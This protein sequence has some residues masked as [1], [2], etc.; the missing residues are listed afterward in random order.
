MNR[1][2]GLLLLVALTGAPEVASGQGC[3]T[4]GSS[5]LG[6]LSGS[7]LQP[8][9]F[10]LGV[11]SEAF[12]LKQAYR[13]TSRVDDA[14]RRESR[15]FTA[16]AYLRVA[17]HHRAVALVQLPWEFSERTAPYIPETGS[18]AQDFSNSALGDL[19]TLVLVQVLPL[20]GPGP[21]T[22]NLGAGI[23]WPT[24]PNRNTQDGLIL[25]VE[26]QTGT[27]S[28]DPVLALVAHALYA[29]GSL[30]ANAALR[31]PAEGETGYEYGNELNF[32][33]TGLWRFGG[34]WHAGLECRGRSAAADFFR[35]FL[36]PN[37]GGTRITVGP[38]VVWQP[39]SLPLGVEGSFQLPVFHDLN[40]TQLGVSEGAALGLRGTFR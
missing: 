8:W 38:R 11:A 19:V 20:R 31:L 26:L 25:P 32:A 17:V 3:C 28:T 33:L 21:Y 37:T 40:G 10:E 24:G 30:S 2:A 16:V 6:G 35:E 27:G 34:S 13:G 7:P 1:G 39:A 29:W 4:P 23:K 36:R 5:P 15:V 9:Q 18:P 12:H 14:S 22:L